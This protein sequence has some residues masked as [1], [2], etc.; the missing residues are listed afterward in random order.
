[1]DLNQ[2]VIFI[3]IVAAGLAKGKSE[4]EINILSAFFSQLEDT[5]ATI[6]A[7]NSS[8]NSKNSG[9]NYEEE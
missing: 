2:F 9:N 3:S 8:C 5:L 6:L 4:E 1:M 7:V